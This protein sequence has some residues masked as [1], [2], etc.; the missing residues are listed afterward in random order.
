MGSEMCIRDSIYSY[1]KFVP[2]YVPQR[3]TLLKWLEK[4]H[5]GYYD[6]IM[7]VIRDE[8]KLQ[9]YIRKGI[10]PPW[11]L[12]PEE[13]NRPD[14]YKEL[15]QEIKEE[16]QRQIEFFKQLIEKADEGLFREGKVAKEIMR[17]LNY[18]T[19]EQNVLKDKITKYLQV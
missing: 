15:P 17:K 13:L 7:E 11:K 4:N 3:D 19:I 8:K 10:T 9:Y 16:F 12:S 6:E 14:P 18:L 5:S 2:A 1:K